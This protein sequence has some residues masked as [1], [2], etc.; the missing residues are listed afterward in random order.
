MSALIT[1]YIMPAS[2]VYASTSHLIGREGDPFSL[3]EGES[4][5]SF[6]RLRELVFFCLCSL[7]LSLSYLQHA[8]YSSTAVLMQAILIHDILSTA[9]GM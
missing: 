5:S 2:G 7:A 9:L 6:K 1:A 8:D 4:D 3:P